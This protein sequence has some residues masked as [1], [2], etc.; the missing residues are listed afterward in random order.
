[1]NVQ[2]TFFGTKKTLES[3]SKILK[4]STGREPS[5]LITFYGNST[6]PRHKIV[7]DLEARHVKKMM[8]FWYVKEKGNKWPW[9]VRVKN[10]HIYLTSFSSS[11]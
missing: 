2:Y 10:H 6:T 11:L 1:M 3:W 7:I 5:E 9:F 8:K 4:E